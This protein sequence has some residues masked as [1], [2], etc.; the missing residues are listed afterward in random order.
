MQCEFLLCRAPR[1]TKTWP[2]NNIQH[3]YM[4]IYVIQKHHQIQPVNS[5]WTLWKRNLSITS[6]NTSFNCI[7]C[8]T[9]VTPVSLSSVECVRAIKSFLWALSV[10]EVHHPWVVFGNIWCICTVISWTEVDTFFSFFILQGFHGYFV[11]GQA[12]AG[13]YRLFESYVYSKGVHLTC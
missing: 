3:I 11:W 10:I 6:C 4:Y 8:C 13:H 1:A 7:C 5:T 12:L 2:P 9:A